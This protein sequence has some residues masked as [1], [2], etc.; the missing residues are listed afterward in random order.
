MP[1]NVRD[2]RDRRADGYE[3]SSTVD[4]RLDS[5]PDDYDDDDEYDEDP[6]ASL[7]HQLAA[8][9]QGVREVS[10]ELGRTTV[11]SRIQHVLIVTKARDN[12]LIRLTRELALYLMLRQQPY[13]PHSAASS[14]TDLSRS[15]ERSDRS[16]GNGRRGIVVYVDSQLRD[17]KRFD[18]AGLQREYP[19]LFE[20]IA[21]RRSSSTS[22]SSTSLSTMSSS[23][24]AASANGDSRR[25]D[26]EGQLRYW[27]ADLC[28]SAPQ[29]FDFVVTLGGDGTVLFT[30]WLL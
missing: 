20:P 12:G 13:I 8:T 4:T 3:S 11:H 26:N 25:K 22:A 29:L 18:A 19:Q 5:P 7:T 16:N 15:S 14:V 9:A 24:S 6:S 28:S 2:S 17:S 30:S 10:K 21:R 1:I 23:W 27:T